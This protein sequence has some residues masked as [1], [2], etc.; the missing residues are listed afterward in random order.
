[1]YAPF[2]QNEGDFSAERSSN[3]GKESADFQAGDVLFVDREVKVKSFSIGRE[4]KA[5]DNRE[6]VVPLAL[7]MDRG[8]AFG[9]PSSAQ[10]GLEHKAALVDKD[11]SAAIGGGVFLYAASAPCATS[12][13]PLCS[14]RGRGAVVSDKSSQ[15]NAGFSRHGPDDRRCQN[16]P[17]LPGRRG[18]ASKADLGNHRRLNLEEGVLEA[19]LSALRTGGT[20]GEAEVAPLRLLGLLSLLPLSNSSL[21][22]S[23]YCIMITRD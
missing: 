5:A 15:G 10:D 20:D 16:A 11:D 23:A 22:P 6:P 7:V 13:L 21:I 19:R 18:G 3:R 2:V 14:V 4:A 17:L 9:R 8:L 12:G 1:M